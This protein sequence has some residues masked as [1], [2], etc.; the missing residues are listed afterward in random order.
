MTIQF[1]Q[2]YYCIYCEKNLIKYIIKKIHIYKNLSVNSLLTLYIFLIN[3]LYKNNNALLLLLL[4][5][6]EYNTFLLINNFLIN[7]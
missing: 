3:T 6:K 5:I 7:L 4:L 1:L 2:N